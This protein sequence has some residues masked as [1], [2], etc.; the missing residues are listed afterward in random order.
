[1]NIKFE[2]GI[3][4]FSTDKDTVTYNINDGTIIKSDGKQR[5]TLPLTNDEIYDLIWGQR[6]L[7]DIM[8]KAL[9]QIIY[10]YP[11]RSKKNME[12]ITKGLKIID[13]INNMA[14]SKNRT[15]SYPETICLLSTD[16]MQV[17]YD[18]LQSRSKLKSAYFNEICDML[19]NLNINNVLHYF[20]K[21]VAVNSIQQKCGS[22]DSLLLKEIKSKNCLPNDILSF[23]LKTIDEN[24]D[25][26]KIALQVMDKI[27]LQNDE[28]YNSF[29]LVPTTQNYLEQCE[30]MSVTPRIVKDMIRETQEIARSYQ[31]FAQ[32]EKDKRFL[33]NYNKYSDILNFSCDGYKIVLP[34]CGQDLVTEGAKMHHCVGSYV[35]RVTNGETLI[36]FVRKE[37][38]LNKPYIT[39]QI[40]PK[41]FDLGQYYLAYDVYISLP[42]DK[43]FKAKYQLHLYENFLQ[44]E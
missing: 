17:V 8:I 5:V 25:K 11:H 10:Y 15:I 37:Q 26:A 2:K 22:S 7:Q 41:T 3:Y 33:E 27:F 30:K 23:L 32:Q 38:D 40:D 21:Y 9:V 18:F 29:Q 4:S 16:R 1:M 24:C 31:L 43:M 6:N 36:V 14:I 19:Q 35:N 34:K 13:I 39:A 42:A 44:K 12:Y 28:E 20:Y